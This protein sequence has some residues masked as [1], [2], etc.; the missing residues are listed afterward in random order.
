MGGVLALVL[1][2][3]AAGAAPASS[4]GSASGSVAAISGSSMEVQNPSTGQTTVNWT[5]TTQFSRTVTLTSTSISAGECVNVLGTISKMSKTTIAAR[6]V[7]VSSP[8]SGGSCSQGPSGSAFG[9]GT[10]TFTGGSGGAGFP[11]GG[12]GGA[13][14]FGGGG[15]TFRG[16][17]GRFGGAGFT[18]ASGKVTSVNG[19]TVS[20]TGVVLSGFTRPSGTTSASKKKTSAPKRPT[21][22]TEKLKVTVPKST[23]ITQVQPTT[24]GVLAIGD[25]VAAF[26]PQS[27]T[28][29]VTATTVRITATGST[30]CASG[31]GFRG[32]GG[33]QGGAGA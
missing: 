19:T 4:F 27:T 23:T 25:C 29:A 22:K 12:T 15:G 21:L 13:R 6:A 32:G 1:S 7:T 14:T 24:A 20:V 2:G 9:A 5:G 16:A 30:T 3:G 11:P 8:A 17:A 26:G 31:F 33:P 28:G 10:R 18:S